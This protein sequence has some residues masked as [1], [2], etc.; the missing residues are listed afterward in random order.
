MPQN[1]TPGRALPLSRW[2]V[3]E[4][5]A[6]V[7]ASVEA[8]LNASRGGRPVADYLSLRAALS[9]ADDDDVRLHVAPE[10]IVDAGR[11][12]EDPSRY[13]ALTREELVSRLD[14]A[15]NQLLVADEKLRIVSLLADGR[16]EHGAKINPAP[17]PTALRGMIRDAAD[18][19]K[20]RYPPGEQPPQPLVVPDAVR[21]SSEAR[22]RRKRAAG[23]PDMAM[24]IRMSRTAAREARARELLPREPQPCKAHG[25][26]DHD[27]CPFG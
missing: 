14:W 9:H 1:Q 11:P 2:T 24:T 13:D 3:K 25:V 27:E 20:P 23:E 12:M 19:W 15:L 6:Y 18:R 22:P 26:V 7:A 5:T 21:P 17:T 4:A 16:D 10:A 8:L